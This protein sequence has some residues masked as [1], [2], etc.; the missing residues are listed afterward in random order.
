MT[1]TQKSPRSSTFSAAEKAAMK[2]RAIELK[3]EARRGADEAA[4]EADVLDAIAKLPEPDHQ[5]AERLYAIIKSAAPEL[6]PKTWYGFV[7]FAKDGK[8]V[9]FYQDA[10]KFKSRYGEL[11]FSDKA[12]LDDGAMWPCRYALKEMTPA[13]EARIAELVKKAAS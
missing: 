4:G 2:Q 13:V 7:A 11:G 1:D 12:N 9:V 5:I 8:N 10:N 3:A 6:T